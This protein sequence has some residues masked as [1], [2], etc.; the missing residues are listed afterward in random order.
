MKGQSKAMIN[1]GWKTSPTTLELNPQK[2]KNPQ[3]HTETRYNGTERRDAYRLNLTA[4][5][6]IKAVLFING[7]MKDGFIKELSANGLSCEFSEPIHLSTSQQIHLMFKL[8]LKEALTIKTK[9][10]FLG[11]KK[12][13]LQNSKTCRFEFSETLFNHNQE[14]IH[15]YVLSKQMD[16]IRTTRHELDTLIYYSHV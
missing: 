7:T 6:P 13:R 5:D 11:I 4:F 15:Q 1:S 9:V 8:D 2:E 10:T 12:N 14:S 3:E 16:Q